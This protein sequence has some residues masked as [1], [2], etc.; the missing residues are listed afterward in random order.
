MP[1]TATARLRVEKQNTNE[2]FNTWGSRLNTNSLDLL[3]EA[4]SGVAPVTVNAAVVLTSNN[5]AS[6]Q[7][8]RAVLKL[9]GAG[10]F[11]VTAPAVEKV[12]LVHNGCA[13]DVTITAGGVGAVIR[14][15]ERCAVYCDGTDFFKA[16]SNDAGGNRLRNVGAPSA[17][18]DAA[19]KAYVDAAAN[20]SWLFKNSAYTAANGDRIVADT[21]AGAWSLTL[22]LAPAAGAQVQVVD[23]KATWHTNNLTVLRNGQTIAGLAE[24]C[25]LNQPAAWVTFVFTGATW[26]VGA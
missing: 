8:R 14:A 20:G 7:A 21:S 17:A 26:A 9:T 25:T 15:G 24:D 12:Y 13:A 11:T 23:A 22:P 2:N 6:D 10:G 16:F 1:S 19:T 3:D 4:I 18:D 5:Y